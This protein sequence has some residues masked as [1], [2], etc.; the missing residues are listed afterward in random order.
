MWDDGF[1]LIL[2]QDTPAA[3]K[4]EQPAPGKPAGGQPAGGQPQG[5]LGPMLF[6]IVAIAV[7]WYF[8]L[9]RPQRREQQR[10]DQLLGGL[11]KDDRVV[12]I[13][14]IIGSVANISADGR[15]VTVKVDDNTRLR[16]LRTAIQTVLKDDAAAK[17]AGAE[18]PA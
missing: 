11:K 12:T 2:A 9:L 17:S 15:E 5:G 10:R 7:L 3:P 16:F 4:A 13:G 18:K 6:P 1:P 14:G 8:L